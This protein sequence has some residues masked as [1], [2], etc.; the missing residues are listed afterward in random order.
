MECFSASQRIHRGSSA[1]PSRGRLPD[2]RI[3]SPDTSGTSIDLAEKN[4]VAGGELRRL[5]TIRTTQDRARRD[6]TIAFRADPLRRHA[7]DDQ[8]R[9]LAAGA[10]AERF[11]RGFQKIDVDAGEI[12]DLDA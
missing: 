5:I 9:V 6:R 2:H 1:A 4:F 12:A 7:L 8:I 3:R 10:V 11:E